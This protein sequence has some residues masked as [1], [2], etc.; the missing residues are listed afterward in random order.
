MEW[1]GWGMGNLQ[2]YAKAQGVQQKWILE[3]ELFLICQRT[4]HLLFMTAWISV[5][6]S[7]SDWCYAVDCPL[8]TYKYQHSWAWC[9]TYLI[10]TYRRLTQEDSVQPGL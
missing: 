2:D 10:L 6:K 3:V 4:F 9:F 5:R 1:V 8:L 7:C